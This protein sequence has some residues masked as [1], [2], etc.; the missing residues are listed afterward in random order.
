TT[1]GQWE[2]MNRN[3]MPLVTITA[4]D[5][6]KII[7]DIA[8][9]ESNWNA[10]SKKVLAEGGSLFSKAAQKRSPYLYGVLRG[11]H[12]SRMADGDDGDPIAIVTI[13]HTPHHV[14]GGYAD[15]YGPRIHREGRPWFG[16]T[17]EQEGAQIMDKIGAS[18][19][20]VFNK[21]LK[22]TSGSVAPS[23]FT[24]EEYGGWGPDKPWKY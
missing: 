19:V 14:L 5:F 16:H 7:N 4:V 22:G 9:F 12:Y 17:I 24:G 20:R 23:A 21:R 3:A 1:G 8:T 13:A 10:D 15:D 11:A 18:M 6:E 2:Y